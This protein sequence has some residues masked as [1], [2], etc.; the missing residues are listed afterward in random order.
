M[1]IPGILVQ[2][3]LLAFVVSG[4]TQPVAPDSSRAAV[5]VTTRSG[6][7]CTPE[8]RSRMLPKMLADMTLKRGYSG[9]VIV[10]H[11]TSDE[12]V[13]VGGPPPEPPTRGVTDEITLAV[14]MRRTDPEYAKATDARNVLGPQWSSFIGTDILWRCG[15]SKEVEGR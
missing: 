10:A 1:R 3:A 14:L 2:F 7:G 15:T 13:R 9:Y 11:G 12:F 4:C 8:E 5:E 6:A